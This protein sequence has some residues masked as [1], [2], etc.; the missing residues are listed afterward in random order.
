MFGG[1]WTSNRL[2]SVVF[3]PFILSQ[4][5][6]FALEFE[7]KPNV[8][9]VRDELRIETKEAAGGFAY[10]L[11]Q[12]ISLTETNVK[13]SW[14]WKVKQFPNVRPKPPFKKEN[15]DF[16][17][18]VGLLVS[19]GS[20]QIPLPRKL[21]KEIKKRNQALSYVLFYCASQDQETACGRSPFHQNVL[22][23]LRPAQGEMESMESRPLADLKEAYALSQ[24]QLKRLKVFGIWL[25]ADSDNSESKTF[26][27]VSQLQIHH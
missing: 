16:A 7:G 1:K 23:C 20:S 10:L 24:N 12:A 27:S 18:R 13:F 2:N 6:P 8:Q 26:A 25:F 3:A 5:M 11:P 21:K 14:K 22:N 17:L 19:D 9:V 15:E 4:W